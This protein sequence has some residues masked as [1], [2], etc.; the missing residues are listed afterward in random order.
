[1]KLE[2]RELPVKRWMWSER[3]MSCWYHCS[4]L[5]LKSL[6]EGLD[7]RAGR[8]RARLLGVLA[9]RYRCV[10]TVVTFCT[11]VVL[12]SSCTRSDCCV[13]ASIEERSHSE[14][15]PLSVLVPVGGRALDFPLCKLQAAC[16]QSLSCIAL[17]AAAGVLTWSCGANVCSLDSVNLHMSLVSIKKHISG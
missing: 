5:K 14:A 1:M 6:L 16:G 7:W 12:G 9:F 11:R 2:E 4:S 15:H 13:D 8:C 17:Q 3:T 10:I